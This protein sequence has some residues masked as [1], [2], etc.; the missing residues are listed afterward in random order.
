[1]FRARLAFLALA[2]SLLSTVG[3]TSMHENECANGGWF[4]RF[5][6][7]SRTTSA[8]CECEGGAPVAGGD[9]SV[10]VPPNTFVPPG[11]F[12][13]PPPTVMTNPPGAQPSRRGLFPSRSSRLFLSLIHLQRSK[14]AGPGLL[15]GVHQQ[16]HLLADRARITA[17]SGRCADLSE[18]PDQGAAD[19]DSIR[20]ARGA[21]WTCSGLL[22]P[23]PTHKGRLV[24]DRSQRS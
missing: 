13:P 21:A 12:A 11:A 16:G 23:K 4:S 20:K 14:L 8:P 9:G 3:C 19:D 22:M 17:S 15:Q 7:A 6:L 18:M 10:M 2:S 24:W 5:R 1:M